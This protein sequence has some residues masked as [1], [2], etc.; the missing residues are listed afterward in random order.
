MQGK[1]SKVDPA[2][3]TTIVEWKQ[4]ADALNFTSFVKLT[5]HFRDLICNYTCIEGPLR[6]LLKSVPLPQ[7]YTK[8]T[9]WKAMELFKLRD[10][11][12]L[13]HTKAF[14][15]LKCTLVPE[16]VLKAPQW[17]RSSFIITMDGL[18]GGFCG[19]GCSAFR[20]GTPE[21]YHN[22]QDT[23]SGICIQMNI[24]C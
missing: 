9:Y 11:W 5:G 19:G 6:N 22:L 12:T 18:Q 4:P 17:D 23:P 15:E 21:W 8:S 20:S 24:K 10:K 1:K 2:K 3:L 13:D 16:P 7:H 14:L